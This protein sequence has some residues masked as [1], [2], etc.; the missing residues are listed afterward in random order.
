MELSKQYWSMFPFPTPGDF[1]NPGI[2]PVSLAVYC[3]G[4]RIL[5][6][7]ATWEATLVPQT[8]NSAPPPVINV[9]GTLVGAFGV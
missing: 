7:Y 9:L 8:G 4:S 1:P 6:Q 2:K 3:T 5:Y